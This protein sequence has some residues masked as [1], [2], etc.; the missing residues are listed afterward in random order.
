M[1]GGV[2]LRVFGDENERVIK[3]EVERALKETKVGK[4]A[5]MDGVRADILK[6]GGVTVLEWLVRLL[7]T[8]FFFFF[9]FISSAS[10]LGA[11]LYSF[12][13]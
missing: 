6:K 3:K 10:G 2:E 7:K 8:C 9:F 4:A 11:C 5:G 12:V 13:V 1:N